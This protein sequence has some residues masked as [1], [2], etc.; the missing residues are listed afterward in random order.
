MIQVDLCW[1]MME[2]QALDANDIQAHLN[3]MALMH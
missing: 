3:E 2:K 1:K